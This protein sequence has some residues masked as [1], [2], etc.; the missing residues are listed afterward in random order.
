MTKALVATSSALGSNVYKCADGHT[1]SAP[2]NV[3]VVRCPVG[4]C[5]H[6]SELTLIAVHARR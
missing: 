2:G 6:P 4:W 3:S 5:K 1:T